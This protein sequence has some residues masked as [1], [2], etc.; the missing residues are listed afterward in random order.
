MLLCSDSSASGASSSDTSDNDI[1]HESSLNFE[2]F[3]EEVAVNLCSTPVKIDCLTDNDGEEPQVCTHIPNANNDESQQSEFHGGSSSAAEMICTGS[4]LS[5]QSFMKYEI[6]DLADTHALSERA[7]AGILCLFSKAMP[8]ANNLPTMYSLR[9][10]ENSLLSSIVEQKIPEGIIFDLNFE[11]QLSHMLSEKNDLITAEN[12]QLQTD[13]SLPKPDK[14]CLFF[15]LCTDGVSPFNSAKFNLYPVR[16]MLF[17]LPSKRRVS[18]K[19]LLLL[20]LFGGDRKSK[21]DDLMNHTV[22]NFVN[23]NAVRR[24]NVKGSTIE[25]NAKIHYVI[26]DMVMK[27]PLLNQTQFNGRCGCSNCLAIGRRAL[28]KDVW[29]YPFNE[30]NVSE[31]TSKDRMV[32]LGCLKPGQKSLFVLR[33][34]Q[35][36]SKFLK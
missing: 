27:A 10:Q 23:S 5:T 8:S 2:D 13:L 21:V 14:N 18:Y 17:N 3:I 20:S 24:L 32:V 19:N 25:F 4:K 28:T 29:I 11:R 15:A 16:V 9:Q 22:K 35:K 7:V 30:E 36:V 26:V 6:M 34:K 31:R 1:P 33:G 12:F